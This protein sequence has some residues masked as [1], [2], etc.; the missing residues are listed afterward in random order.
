MWK[1]ANIMSTSESGKNAPHTSAGDFGTSTDFRTI[2]PGESQ[3]I[4]A[5]LPDPAVLAQ[6]ANEF[7]TALPLSENSAADGQKFV[8]VP[9]TPEA[10][11]IARHPTAFVS[12]PGAASLPSTSLP[13]TTIPFTT[14][15]TESGFRGL[16]GASSAATTIPGIATQSQFPSGSDFSAPGIPGGVRSAGFSAL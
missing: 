10:F 11:G 8:T 7:F 14:P 5:G 16:P 2:L 6:M 3:V 12:L 4:P 1:S 15:P 13:S 9:G